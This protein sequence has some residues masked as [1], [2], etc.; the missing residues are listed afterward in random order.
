MEF[1]SG[2]LLSVSYLDAI[3]EAAVCCNGGFGPR[4]IQ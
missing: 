1:S 4:F 3:D 2:G